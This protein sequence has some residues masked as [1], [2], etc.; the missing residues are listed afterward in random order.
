L[1]STISSSLYCVVCLWE[2]WNW[3]VSDEEKFKKRDE[4]MNI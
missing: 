1:I 4:R 3:F 2:I